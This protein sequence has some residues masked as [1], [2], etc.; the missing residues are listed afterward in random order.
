M[1]VDGSDDRR[2]LHEIGPGAGHAQDLEEP[3]NFHF[4]T[5]GAIRR[6]L[7][8]NRP[9]EDPRGRARGPRGASIAYAADR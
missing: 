5:G 9:L 1:I 6:V 7:G 8:C 2:E 3:R 4:V